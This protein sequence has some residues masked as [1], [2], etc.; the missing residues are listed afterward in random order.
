MST[1]LAAPATV[2]H[3]KP[4][5]PGIYLK[6]PFEEYYAW[7]ALSSHTLNGFSRTPAHVYHSLLTGEEEETKALRMGWLVHLATLEPERFEAEVV[8]APVADKRSPV[9]KA[10][11]ADFEAKHQGKVIVKADELGAVKAMAR[12]YHSHPK[13][14]EFLS[15]P[16]QNELSIV[17][18]DEATGVRCKARLDRLAQL[19]EWPIIGDFKSARD[20]SEHAWQNAVARYG[21]DLQ[22]SHYLAG[23]EAHYPSKGLHRRFVHF[24]VESE[25]PYCVAVYELDDATIENAVTK[26]RRYLRLWTE[27]TSSGNWP[28]YS[29]QVQPV[30]LPRWALTDSGSEE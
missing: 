19:E 16:G 2:L 17:W 23:L 29:E 27:C 28:G 12:A 15:G 4:I 6:A 30:G 22:A 3:R 7:A 5:A 26:R 13:S 1:S 14:R 25:P 24:V 18:D 20:A 21:Y 8:A 10:I 11:W 9:G